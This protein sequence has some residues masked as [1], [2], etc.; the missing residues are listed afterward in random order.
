MPRRKRINSSNSSHT[1]NRLEELSRRYIERTENPSA[2]EEEIISQIGAMQDLKSGLTSGKYSSNKIGYDVA[3]VEERIEELYAR[4]EPFESRRMNVAERAFSSGVSTALRP[5]NLSRDINALSMSSGMIS[6]ASILSKYSSNELERMKMSATE[7]LLRSSGGILEAI[8]ADPSNPQIGGMMRGLGGQIH[9]AAA[10]QAAMALQRRTGTD[11]RSRYLNSIERTASLRNMIAGEDLA[12]D[13][14]AGRTG[15]RSE[16]EGTLRK[17]LD[18]IERFRGAQE[19]YSG[20]TSKFER[21][22][23]AIDRLTASA[24]TAAKTL[25]EMDR[26]GRGGGG[27][28]FWDRITSPKGIAGLQL[29]GEAFATAGDLANMYGV[30]LPQ[31]QR[32]NQISFAGFGNQ[33]YSDQMAAAGGNAAAIRRLTSGYRAAAEANESAQRWSK[34]GTVGLGIGQVLGGLAGT[35]IGVATSEVGVGIPIAIGGLELMRRGFKNVINYSEGAGEAGAQAAQTEL[36]RQDA[37]SKVS[38]EQMQSYI[39]YTRSL[40]GATVGLGGRRGA[41][42]SQMNSQ[43]NLDLLGSLGVDPTRAAGLT[44]TGTAALGSSFRTN[45]LHRGA[46]LR[47]AGYMTEEQYLGNVGALSNFGSTQSSTQNL[48]AI[49][50]NAIANGMDSSKNIAQMV[51]LTGTM[52]ARSAGAGIDTITGAQRVTANLMDSLK[53]QGIDP[54]ARMAVAANTADW[55]SRTLGDTSYSLGTV[56]R[57][58]SSRGLAGNDAVLRGLLST[59]KPE[60]IQEIASGKGGANKFGVADLFY[61]A[62]GKPKPGALDKLVN[63]AIEQMAFEGSGAGLGEEYRSVLQKQFRGQ[64]LNEDE[65]N[66]LKRISAFKGVNFGSISAG[67]LTQAGTAGTVTG[68]TGDVAAVESMKASEALAASRQQQDA[69]LNTSLETLSKSMEKMVSE[70]NFKEINASIKKAADEYAVP[71]RDLAKAAEAL[72]SAAAQFASATGSKR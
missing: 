39:N 47:R 46:E 13:V 21:F 20:D 54:N 32:Q 67:G 8:N 45:M 24:E 55:M 50:K 43:S 61:D 16:V 52:A 68:P 35:A 57:F 63:P 23:K 2:V 25:K 18:D 60:Q 65:Q 10:I 49:L 53:A 56:S 3:Q 69:R 42:F 14:A 34:I 40:G 51:Q 15:T 37:L 17:N 33:T 72:N 70:M 26:Q 6:Q 28:G 7:N 64:P 27:G 36:A 66:R 59:L 1:V 44:A 31:R 41:I 30:E 22:Q 19:R 29:V 58:A 5:S 62:D 12:Q 4:M 48:E 11:V 38:D 71:A 9:S